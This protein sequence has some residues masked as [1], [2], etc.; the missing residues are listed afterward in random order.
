MRNLSASIFAL[1][2]FAVAAARAQVVLNEVVTNPQR[3]WSDSSGGNGVA[4]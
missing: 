3:D 1:G 4:L 2:L